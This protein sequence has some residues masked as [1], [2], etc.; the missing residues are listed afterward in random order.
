MTQSNFTPPTLEIRFF[1][2]TTFHTR[3]NIGGIRTFLNDV[4][5]LAEPP[6]IEWPSRNYGFALVTNFGVYRNHDGT[7]N[8]VGVVGVPNKFNRINSRVLLA[9]VSF[10]TLLAR[11]QIIIPYNRGEIF[12]QNVNLKSGPYTL[13]WSKELGASIQV[14][15]MEF[16]DKNGKLVDVQLARLDPLIWKNPDYSQEK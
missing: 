16:R 4:P 3:K 6:D 2:L 13:E 8:D 15:I 14:D 11:V 9:S 7:L 12:K 5:F 1:N 10:Q